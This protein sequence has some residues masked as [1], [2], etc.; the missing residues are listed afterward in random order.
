MPA[1]TKCGLIRKAAWASFCGECD[2]SNS[3]PPVDCELIDIMNR[4]E[5]LFNGTFNPL[6]FIQLSGLERSIYI[7]LLKAGIT[8]DIANLKAEYG[9]DASVENITWG[10]VLKCQWSADG[11]TGGMESSKYIT[12]NDINYLGY[13]PYPLF[14]GKNSLEIDPSTFPLTNSIPRKYLNTVPLW[15][16]RFVNPAI[17]FILIV[18]IIF[19]LVSGILINIVRARFRKNP[20]IT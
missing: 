18:L 5:M 9:E 6:N 8:S 11:S 19:V 3:N 17:A 12:R 15:M 20:R 14:V 10:D 13:S 7:N 16:D 1:P 4:K 2:P